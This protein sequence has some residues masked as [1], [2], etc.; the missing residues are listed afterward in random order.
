VA[1]ELAGDVE[2]AIA[3]S[4]GLADGLFAVKAELLGPDHDVV[5][6]QGEFEPGG[7]RDK[8]LEREVRAAGRLQCPDAVRDFGALAVDHLQHGDVVAG[9]VGDEALES[10]APR[11]R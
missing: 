9:L 6:N 3:Q 8:A 5:G 4:F 10:D 1:G 2:D 11:G 7:V